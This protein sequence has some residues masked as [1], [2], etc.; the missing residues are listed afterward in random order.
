MMPFDVLLLL[1][2]PNIH[3]LVGLLALVDGVTIATFRS[4]W[5]AMVNEKVE[6]EAG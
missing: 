2:F 4:V 6:E 1:L 3:V 5:M